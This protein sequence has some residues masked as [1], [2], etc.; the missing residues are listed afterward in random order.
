MDK[1][2]STCVIEQLHKWNQLNSVFISKYTIYEIKLD[3]EEKAMFNNKFIYD[4]FD[5]ILF[6]NDCKPSDELKQWA[7]RR[8]INNVDDLYLWGHAMVTAVNCINDKL[9]IKSIIEKA[10]QFQSN[11]KI[12][13]KIFCGLIK[14]YQSDCIK[15]EIMI[16]VLGKSLLDVGL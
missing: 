11:I 9:E 14:Y 5:Q 8:Y 10:K 4:K 15:A 7:A 6:D 2:T 1:S 16:K 3:I 12:K 13:N